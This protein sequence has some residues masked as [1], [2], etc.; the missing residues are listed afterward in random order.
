M[1]RVVSFRAT[2]LDGMQSLSSRIQSD[3]N[4]VQLYEW[5]DR[6]P[7]AVL[8]CTCLQVSRIKTLSS[9]SHAIGG[10][11]LFLHYETPG[12][13]AEVCGMIVG[14]IPK[15][16]QVTYEGTYTPNYQS[17]HAPFG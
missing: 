3:N 12:L 16:D 5:A 10:Q 13:F 6:S 17:C 15:E 11:N 14:V 7:S 9:L 1:E 4:V 2:E 8:K